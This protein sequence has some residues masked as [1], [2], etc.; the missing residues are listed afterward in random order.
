MKLSFSE[1]KIQVQIY[2][3]TV[4]RIFTYKWLTPYTLYKEYNKFISHFFFLILHKLKL[5][6]VETQIKVQGEIILERGQ[7]SFISF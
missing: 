1:F 5:K 7:T 6:F 2:V 4:S 3:H